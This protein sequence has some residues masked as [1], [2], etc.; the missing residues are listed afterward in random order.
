ASQGSKPGKNS[1][2]SVNIQDHL[3]WEVSCILDSRLRKGKLQYL[4]ECTCYQSEKDQT[5]CK[6]ATHL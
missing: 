6:P 2:T 4:I 1:S 5:T 3:E